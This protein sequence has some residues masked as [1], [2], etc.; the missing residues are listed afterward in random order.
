MIKVFEQKTD[1]KSLIDRA[2]RAATNTELFFNRGCGDEEYLDELESIYNAIPPLRPINIRWESPKKLLGL[3]MTNG[4]F[5]SP[6]NKFLPSESKIAHVRKIM[7]E[8]A[9]SETPV[10]IHF[11]GTGDE[12]FKR[13]EFF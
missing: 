8:L 7:P 12:G 11:P 4:S 3:E 2:Y 10:V 6:A 1:Q 5:I 9:N 13:R